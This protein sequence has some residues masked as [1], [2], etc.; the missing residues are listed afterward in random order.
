[1]RRDLPV[2]LVLSVGP[3]CDPARARADFLEAPSNAAAVAALAEGVPW[4]GPALA[5][6]GPPAAGKSHLAAIWRRDCGAREVAGADLGGADASALAAGPVLV[7]DADRVAG[8]RVAE[9]RLLHLYNLIRAEGHRL[10]LTARTPPARW[11]INL[12]DLGSRLAALPLLQIGPPEDAL[13]GALLLK[14]AR[15]RQIN[16]AP[17]V[18]ARLLAGMER[19][20]AG[21]VR[22]IAALDARALAEGRRITVHLAGEVLAETGRSPDEP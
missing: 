10:L 2:Q 22:V 13:L 14:L 19:S 9:R 16:L 3:S 11:G 7:E 6:I 18:V 15:D 1:M 8:D 12:P 20:H 21:A 5:L 4:P 17:A